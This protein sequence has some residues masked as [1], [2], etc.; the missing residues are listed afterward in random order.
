MESVETG[1]PKGGKRGRRFT[2]PGRKD[3]HHQEKVIDLSLV[4]D[5]IDELVRLYKSAAEVAED[6]STAIKETAEKA[7]IN[8]G[9]LR[10]FVTAKAGEKY[11]ERKRDCEQLSLLFEEVGE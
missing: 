11:E 7:G 3:E 8:A 4:S 5:S 6:Y 9:A 10:K 1:K 2:G